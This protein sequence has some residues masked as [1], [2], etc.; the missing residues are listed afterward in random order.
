MKQLIEIAKK[1][2]KGCYIVTLT[3][4]LLDEQGCGWCSSDFFDLV[5]EFRLEMSWGEADYFVHFKMM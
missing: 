3:H 1:C 2:K 4:N 5:D